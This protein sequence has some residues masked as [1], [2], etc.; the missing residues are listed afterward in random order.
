MRRAR[1]ETVDDIEEGLKL[2]GRMP[3]RQRIAYLSQAKSKLLAMHRRGDQVQ[4]L[5]FKVHRVYAAEKKRLDR[6]ARPS[7]SPEPLYTVVDKGLYDL[8]VGEA[9]Y[10][11]SERYHGMLVARGKN[12]VY[13][14]DGKK[15]TKSYSWCG[16]IPSEE[17]DALVNDED[18]TN[19]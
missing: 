5:R 9:T 6:A 16:A 19:A 3:R 7:S 13:V 2:L 1:L 14:T 17:I 18:N 15:R 11:S 12:G 10:S 8:E 4:D